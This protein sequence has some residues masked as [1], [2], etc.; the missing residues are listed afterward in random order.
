[1]GNRHYPAPSPS[2]PQP[3]S[4]FKRRQTAAL[5]GGGANRCTAFGALWVRRI[6]RGDASRS[7]EITTET[8]PSRWAR[9]WAKRSNRRIACARATATS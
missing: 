9:R 5:L 3:A 8:A 2:L 6:Y 1:M 4:V 7:G